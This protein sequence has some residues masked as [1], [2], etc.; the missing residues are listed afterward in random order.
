MSGTF[1]SSCQDAYSSLV[2]KQK[3]IKTKAVELDK[4]GRASQA[5]DLI[6]FRYVYIY[7]YMYICIFIYICT[8]IYICLCVYMNVYIVE[9]DKKGRASQAD[10]L[11][12]FRYPYP[13]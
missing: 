12:Q 13:I 10:D 6:Q 11:I 2:A 9:L 7:V 1:L 3:A 8:Y 4:K 5:D